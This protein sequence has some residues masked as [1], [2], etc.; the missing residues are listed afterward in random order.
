VGA[1]QAGILSIIFVFF[2]LDLFDT[3]GTLIGVTQE[4]GLL[5]PDGKPP[6]RALG[7]AVRRRGYD[8]GRPPGNLYGHELY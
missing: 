6:A 4:A 8:G 5:A 1:F 7:T 2:F 3:V